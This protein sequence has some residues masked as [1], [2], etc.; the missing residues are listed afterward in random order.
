[1]GQRA[2]IA[3]MLV[4]GPEL[5]MAGRADLGARRDGS[6]RSPRDP[7]QAG[8]G[9]RHGADLR[10]RT[11]C[12][13]VSSFCDRVL[14]MYAG[15]IVEEIAASEL[16]NAKA[17]LYTRSPELHA[18]DRVGSPSIAGARPA[19]RSGRY[20]R[21]RIRR[22]SERRLDEFKALD[23]VRVDGCERRVLR[24]RRRIRL[25]Q[26]HPAARRRRSHR[27]KRRNDPGF[28][29]RGSWHAS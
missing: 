26:V 13:L 28:R 19:N 11:I 22:K 27:G 4:A 23:A 6:A 8:G 3:M 18:G 15:R 12:R 9:T 29:P 24:P 21:G 2:M 17:S 16:G 20:D 7:R 14:V 5:L 1:M 25:G 10:S